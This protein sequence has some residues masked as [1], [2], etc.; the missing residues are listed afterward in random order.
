M[1]SHEF[2]IES[3]AY[4]VKLATLALYAGLICGA[5]FWGFGADV[6]GRRF[7]FNSTL[8][9][10]G[11]FGVI[12]GASPSFAAYGVFIALLGFGVGGNLPV[13]GAM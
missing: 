2:F 13:D 12:A 11:I 9:I 8:Y 5:F 7:A 10:G 3:E 1:K 6:V 4:R